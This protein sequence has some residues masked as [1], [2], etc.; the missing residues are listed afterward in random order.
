MKVFGKSQLEYTD[1]RWLT[2]FLF[3]HHLSCFW[4]ACGPLFVLRMYELLTRQTSYDLSAAKW[5]FIKP[6]EQTEWTIAVK[7]WDAC[8]KLSLVVF[9]LLWQQYLT[10]WTLNLNIKMSAYM[11]YNDILNTFRSYL[12]IQ[13]ELNIIQF[14]YCNFSLLCNC[15]D[16][17]NIK[18]MKISYINDQNSKGI[19]KSTITNFKIWRE[20]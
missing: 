14:Y 2:S 1:A 8:L 11:Q 19:R 20:Q 12:W 6:L 3:Y 10:P 7:K 17:W 18:M 4:S 15:K 5:C 13:N 9:F 16:I